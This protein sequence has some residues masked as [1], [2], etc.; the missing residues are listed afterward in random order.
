MFL[1]LVNALDVVTLVVCEPTMNV[2]LQ[3]LEVSR[4]C[5][6]RRAKLVAETREQLRLDA[7]G[8][9][10]LLARTLFAF[11]RQLELACTLRHACI[12]RTIQRMHA[13][14]AS[15]PLR[16]V[17]QQPAQGGPAIATSTDRHSRFDVCNRTLRIAKGEL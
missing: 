14:F 9:F 7:I 17:S 16:H 10:C 4:Y 6:Q 11:E 12:Q 8:R 5:M 1:R 2:L 13:R 15:E 3:N